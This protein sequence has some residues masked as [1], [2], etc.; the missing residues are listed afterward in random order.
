MVVPLGLFVFAAVA[1]VWEFSTSGLEMGMVFGWI[2]LSFWLLVRTE[3]RRDSAISCAFV[4]GLGTLIR[5]ELLLMSIVYLGALATVV[6]ARG[7]RGPAS[8]GKRYLAPVGAAIALPLLYELWRMAYFALIVSNS[9]LAKSA[10]SSRWSQGFTYLWNFV[11]PYTLWLP[12]ALGAL[13]LAPRAWAWGRR[14]DW[15][16]TVVLLTPIGAGLVDVVYVVRL[17]GD[18]QHARLLLP[19]FLSLCL[20]VYF[21]VKQLRSVL[22]IPIIAVLVW[23]VV[24]TGWLRYSTGGALRSDHGITDE[25]NVWQRASGSTHPIEAA[26]YHNVL[27]AYYHGVASIG[28]A[29]HQQLMLDFVPG[30]RIEPPDTQRGA[31]LA[32]LLPRGVEAI[33]VTGYLSG[34]DVYV[35]DELSLANPIGAH[36]IVTRRGRP[37]S[38]EVHRPHLDDRQVRGRDGPP[39]GRR[40]G[41]IGAGSPAGPWPVRHSTHTCRPFRH[42]ST[43]PGRS[44]TWPT[45]S[46]TRPC[47]SAR[48]RISPTRAL[49]MRRLFGGWTAGDCRVRRAMTIARG[50]GYDLTFRTALRPPPSAQ[51]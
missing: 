24:C 43:C 46:P 18:Y 14:H 39:T 6:S 50:D 12:L 1:G 5:P 33:G 31:I 41:R 29:R 35:F 7:W 47:S 20:P 27:G 32:P 16:G 28:R 51:S 40:I 45:R 49:S 26:D 10:A 9:A 38:R 11:A 30:L 37:G 44:P 3:H 36:F 34:S 22:L 21:G 17:G 8:L 25:R 13:L 2:G 23:A 4:I 42:R 15:T 19:A 48:I